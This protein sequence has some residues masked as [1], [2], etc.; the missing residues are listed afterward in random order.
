LYLLAGSTIVA[1]LL[2]FAVS[3]LARRLDLVNENSTL[4]LLGLILLA[5]AITKMANLST[6]MVPLLAGL[7]L[8]NST[9]RPWIWPRHFGTAGGV[10]VLM[11]FVVTG[12]VWSIESLAAGVMLGLAF[13]LARGI[14]KTA[15]VTAL[16]RPSGISIRQGLALGAAMTPISGAALIL[17]AD[18]QLLYPDFA[19]E[20]AGMVFS[21]I[22][23]L[24]LV[25][26][27]V[28]HVALRKVREDNLR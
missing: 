8:R 10:L 19:A 7:V 26:P 5:L 16:S 28:V 3:Q 22:A 2:A 21:A 13:I 20:L 6:L 14:A 25:G 24:E 23:I 12:A 9:E 4:L 11:L 18:L 15:V 1:A 27:I 17:M